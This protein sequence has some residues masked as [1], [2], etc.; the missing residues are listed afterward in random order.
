MLGL[1]LVIGIIVDDAI[2]VLEN[3][4][5]YAE[6]GMSKV[7]ASLVGAREITSA[8]M[9]ASIAILA[10]FMPV[11]FMQGIVGKFFFQFGITISVAVMVSL[12]EAL[13]IAP[14]RCSQFLEVGNANWLSRAMDAIS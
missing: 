12:L 8:A 5:R 2:M 14:M 6:E 4:T 10:I 3:I 11:I 9:A 1:S 13:T 7:Q